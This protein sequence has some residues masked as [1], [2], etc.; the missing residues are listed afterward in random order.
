MRQE[1]RT[2]AALIHVFIILPL[3]GILFVGIIWLNFKEKSR[4][5]V[6]HAL[7]AIFFQCI[8]L[9]IFVVYLIFCI[10]CN[11]IKVF[12]L[13][14][15]ELLIGGNRLILIVS[16]LVYISICLYGATRILLGKDFNYPFVGKKVRKL[17]TE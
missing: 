13:Q 10:F 17:T 11:L 9:I 8:L 6:F 7:Q 1:E 5:V 16:I 12:N 2:I 15:A 3:W 4:E 14:L